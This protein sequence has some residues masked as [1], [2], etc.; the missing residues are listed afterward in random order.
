MA[1][2]RGNYSI[3]NMTEGKRLA[4]YPS[5]VYMCRTIDIDSFVFQPSSN[6]TTIEINDT[7]YPITTQYHLAFNGFYQGQKFQP[8]TQ[9][10]Y[11]VV[12]E[13]R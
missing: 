2:F 4:L 9:G 13:D 1:L 5:G 3:D 8:F 7:E 10:V 12:G 6:K 11:T